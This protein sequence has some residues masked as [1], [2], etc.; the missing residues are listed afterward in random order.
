MPEEH[1]SK[2]SIL[3]K[4]LK[5]EFNNLNLLNKALTHKSY[6]NEISLP[7]KNNERFEFLGDS[8]LDLI[9]SNYMIFKYE[10]LAEG[11]LSK[12]RAAVVNESCL[13]KLAKDINLGNYIF[14]GK[15]ENSSGGRAKPSILSN[16][17]EALV[18]AVFCDSGFQEV[19]KVFLPSLVKEIYK[20]KDAGSF[21]DFKSDLQ[22][23][24]QNR[25]G[26]IPS[27]KVIGEKGPNH[28]KQ[29]TIKVIVRNKELGEGTGRSKKEAEQIAAK[30]ALKY[31][32][33]N[34]G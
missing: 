3:Q 13:A 32:L 16:A 31:F 28:D 10:D 34:E 20:H 21:E 2:L 5:Y 7:L 1:I 33:S 29:Y 4:T 15:G 18:G 27:Y 22:E 17:Y 8:V 12:I 25:L 9:V 14:L 26:C 30:E 11:S 6:T 23:Y 19:S 24:T